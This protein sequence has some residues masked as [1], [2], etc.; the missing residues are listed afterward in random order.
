MTKSNDLAQQFGLLAI[1]LAIGSFVTLARTQ[2]TLPI[3]LRVGLVAISVAALFVGLFS[4]SPHPSKDYQP[5]SSKDHATDNKM[6]IVIPSYPNKGTGYHQT[7]AQPFHMFLSPLRHIICYLKRTVN[8]QREEPNNAG[9]ERP[10]QSFLDALR[11][12]TSALL[13]A[14]PLAPAEP[15][16]SNSR[17][18]F[19][20]AGSLL[21]RGRTPSL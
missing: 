14:L 4:L 3:A 17:C 7:Y 10:Y 21:E 9:N 19:Y 8:Q 2:P 20:L 15:I 18:G 5:N 13:S 1:G 12:L 11:S 6:G 16:I